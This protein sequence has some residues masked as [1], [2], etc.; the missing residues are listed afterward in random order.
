[1]SLVSFSLDEKLQEQDVGDSHSKKGVKLDARGLS[2][3]AKSALCVQ[4]GT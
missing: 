3:R 4:S 1:M 2:K